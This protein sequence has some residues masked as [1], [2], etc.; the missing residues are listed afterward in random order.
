MTVKINDAKNDDVIRMQRIPANLMCDP[1]MQAVYCR[2][3]IAL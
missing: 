3:I 2:A 1:I